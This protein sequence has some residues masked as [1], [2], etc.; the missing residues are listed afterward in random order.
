MAAVRG[1]VLYQ[2]KEGVLTT[3]DMARRGRNQRQGRHR[4]TNSKHPTRF[5]LVLSPAGTVLVLESSPA[6]VAGG[7]E[8]EHR[9]EYEYRRKRLSTSTSTTGT[10]ARHAKQFE[11][12][13]TK[14]SKAA[15]REG[16]KELTLASPRTRI[17][18]GEPGWRTRFFG[19]QPSKSGTALWLR[20]AA[21]P[22]PSWSANPLRE[23]RTILR[24][25]ETGVPLEGAAEVGLVEEAGRKRNL[26]QRSVG[27]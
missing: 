23:Q 6:N 1:G 22:G 27:P 5:V 26:D 8:Y 12:S 21:A 25:R 9:F 4:E 17:V 3:K 11:V 16:S 19:G 7:L 13:D 20:P 2:T 10:P 15:I 18:E 14:R 24:R